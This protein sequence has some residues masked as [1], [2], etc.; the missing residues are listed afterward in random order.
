M[1]SLLT[2]LFDSTNSKLFS[3]AWSRSSLSLGVGL[4]LGLSL[5]PGSLLP[6]IAGEANAGSNFGRLELAPG[7]SPTNVSGF[8]GGSYSLSALAN[9]DKNGSPCVGYGDTKPD[10]ILVLQK[11]L[12]QLSL[13]LETQGQDSTLVIQGPDG[14]RCSD[15]GDAGSSDAKVSQGPWVPGT[16]RVWVGLM[17]PGT[18][19]NYRLIVQN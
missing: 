11:P 19:V 18:R 2:A 9:R 12:A 1:L 10:H 16:Y 8:T 17:N 4:V 6:A 7:F 14:F 13:Q 3:K 5:V 15:D